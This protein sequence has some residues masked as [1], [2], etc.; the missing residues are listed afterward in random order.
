MHTQA[1][2]LTCL[3][4]PWSACRCTAA[5]PRRS[6]CRVWSGSRCWGSRRLQGG[7]RQAERWA[8]LPRPYEAT[9]NGVLGQSGTGVPAA[10]GH[11]TAR[12]FHCRQGCWDPGTPPHA[13]GTQRTQERLVAGHPACAV[14]HRLVHGC[15]KD[16][17]A[18]PDGP[19]HAGGALRR[20]HARSGSRG[21]AT[22]AGQG[23]GAQLPASSFR[24]L[25]HTKNQTDL[26]EEPEVAPH[27]EGAPSRVPAAAAGRAAQWEL[28]GGAASAGEAPARRQATT[29]CCLSQAGTVAKAMAV[30]PCCA[31]QRAAQPWS[32]QA[33]HDG[34]GLR[35]QAGVQQ[36]A[37]H[38]RAQQR[39]GSRRHSMP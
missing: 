15:H 29:H 5:C 3:P 22:R 2:P 21:Q 27:R 35:L 24:K 10:L 12:C 26:C 18:R 31:L 25:L 37:Q 36:A 23:I 14:Q 7:A 16:G 30:A 33:S 34:A 17:V 32:N 11:S 39:G 4:W 19:G 20:T 13:K 28:E 9:K 38:Q 6:T 8:R 1:A